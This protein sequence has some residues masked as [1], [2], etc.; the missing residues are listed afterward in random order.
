MKLKRH[1][2]NPIVAPGGY[3]WRRVATFNPGVVLDE[4]GVFWMLERACSNLAPLHSHFG[5]LR[6][7]DGMHF[8][9]VSDEPVFTAAQLGTPRGTVEDARVVRIDGTYYMTYVH[10][11]YVS[12]CYPNGVGIPLYSDPSDVPDEDLNNYR[13]GVA[14]SADL[15]NWEDLGL[16]TGEALDDRDCVL[17]PEKIDGRFAMLRRPMNFVGP[18][19][20]CDGPSIWLSYS[21]DLLEWTTPALVATPENASWEG[22]KIG[23][24]ATPMKTDDG[25]LIIYHGVDESVTYRSGVMLLD[26]D[27]PTKLVARSPEF[28]LEPEEYYERTGL[29]I[30]HVV[31]PSANVV[32]DDTVFIYYGCCD[33][34]ISLATVPLGDLLD[35]VLQ[36]RR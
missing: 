27:D 35:Y 29:I 3:S 19:F 9:H 14:K 18:E 7:D 25:W 21:D 31:F 10:R 20:G 4:D 5:L 13:S 1:E 32:K 12:S 6:S 11:N 26:L 30:P 33:T 24:G 16:V 15:Q 17:F 8:E 34:C 36:Y 22:G 28:I 23:A 2:E